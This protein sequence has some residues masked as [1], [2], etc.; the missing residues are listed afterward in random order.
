M[1]AMTIEEWRQVAEALVVW[2]SEGSSPYPRRNPAAVL[3]RYGQTEGTRLLTIIQQLE[4]D[5]FSCTARNYAMTLDELRRIAKEEFVA[6]YPD[7]PV[8]GLK[9]LDWC[10]SYDNR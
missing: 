1:G 10:Y 6:K 2:S 4:R 5:Y 7:L 8:E 9:V 3:E